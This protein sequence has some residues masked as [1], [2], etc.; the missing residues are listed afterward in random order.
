MRTAKAMKA[1]LAD[2]SRDAREIVHHPAAPI[3][4]MEALCKVMG[5]RLGKPI[6]LRLRAFPDSLGA[7]GLT[8]QLEHSILLIV[9]ERTR[10]EHQLII[11]G[12]ELWHVQ[13]GDCGDHEGGIAA[14]ARRFGAED[15]PMDVL[16]AMAAR[17]GSHAQHEVDAERFGLLVGTHFRSWLAGPYARDAPSDRTVAGRIASFLTSPHGPAA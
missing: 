1:L 12:H 13:N 6:K 4:L 16:V 15:V 8:L 7:S 14:A 5:D 2:L 3:E 10:P 9:E 17:S 11:A